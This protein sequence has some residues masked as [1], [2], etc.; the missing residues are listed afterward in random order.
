MQEKV[1]NTDRYW[2]AAVWTFITYASCL[3]VYFLKSL[4]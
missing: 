2:L 3:S 4:H 1:F